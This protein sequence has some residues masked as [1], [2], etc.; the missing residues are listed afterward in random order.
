MLG[1]ISG[2][3]ATDKAPM[4]ETPLTCALGFGGLDFGVR[5]SIC[6]YWGLFAISFV[7]SL[8]ILSRDFQGSRESR[9]QYGNQMRLQLKCI[10]W[11]QSEGCAQGTV[12]RGDLR[13]GVI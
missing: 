11:W 7:I 9:Q 8:G 1:R 13:R 2:H 12:T 10:N 4:N 6:L 3:Y 5:G